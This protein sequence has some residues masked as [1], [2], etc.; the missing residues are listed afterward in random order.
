M[1]GV[2]ACLPSR[3]SATASKM[4]LASS[5]EA[6]LTALPVS[7]RGAKV[8]MLRASSPSFELYT[9]TFTSLWSFMG[10]V[11]I[12]CSC[13]TSEPDLVD[14]FR[15]VISTVLFSPCV[16]ILRLKSFI[17]SSCTAASACRCLRRISSGTC[18]KYESGML[19]RN[20]GTTVF[21]VSIWCSEMSWMRAWEVSFSRFSG[22]L[23]S[24]AKER[25]GWRCRVGAS[26]ARGA[27]A[28][29]EEGRPPRTE[30]TRARFR[31]RARWC[32]EES[33]GL[34]ATK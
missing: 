10:C 3:I 27:V 5:T 13:S 24:Q 22:L 31:L 11:R 4:C 8:K 33:I 29:L 18:E 2:S 15:M 14:E 20:Q 9:F 23:V 19:V 17:F 1:P 34:I 21:T 12:C 30:A 26:R 28:R 25:A 16:M 7:R 32:W 6:L